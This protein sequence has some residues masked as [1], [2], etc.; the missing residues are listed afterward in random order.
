MKLAFLCPSMAQGTFYGT[1]V[2]IMG[3]AADRLGVDLE[4]LDGRRDLDR[5]VQLGVG[6]AARQPRPDCVLLPNYKGTAHEILEALDAAGVDA[7]VLVEGMTPT[8]R[9]RFG[10]P[11]TRHRHWLGELYPDDA[12]AGRLLAQLLVEAARARGLAA[13]GGAIHVGVLPGDQTPA[14]QQRFQGWLA[15]RKE[16]PEVAQAAVQ[17]AGWQEEPARAAAEVMLRSHPEITVVW[18]ANDDMALGALQGARDAGR[19][20]GQDVLVGGVDLVAPALQRVA[21]GSMAVSLGGHVLDGARALLL[22]HDHYQGHDFEPRIRR[23]R[24]EPVTAELAPAYLR[25]FEGERWRGFEFERYSRARGGAA[26]DALTL[27]ALL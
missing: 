22:V 10:E 21:E 4:V 2:S 20:P 12:A 11:R 15:L 14:G 24:L 9:L 17:Y 27:Q 8:D 19:R 5:F 25:V 26:G 3:A 23:T 6:L 1:L 7:F 13:P 18:A 16:R